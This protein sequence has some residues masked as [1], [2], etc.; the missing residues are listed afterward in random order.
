M[1]KVIITTLDNLPMLKKQVSILRDDPL[2]SEIIVTS[3]GSKDGTN[4]WLAGQD[5]LTAVI[6]ENKGAGPGRNAGLD[7]AGE[8][9]FVLMLDGAIR[10]LRGGAAGMLTYMKEHPKVDVLSPEVA[11]CYTSDKDA[12]HRRFV[13]IG[14]TFQQ[15]ALSGT[16]YALCNKRAW[17]DLRFSEEG[18]FGQPGWGVD[19]NEMA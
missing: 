8:F 1:V 12:A 2:I 13:G 18:P 6:R 4:E 9:G 7:A 11:T 19:D 3:N 15:R 14:H 5:D 17:N 16:A 10:P